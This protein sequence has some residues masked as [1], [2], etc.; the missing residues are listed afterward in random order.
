MKNH[1]PFLTI[2][3]LS[4]V[5]LMVIVIFFS[6]NKKPVGP[7]AETE[8]L[9]GINGDSFRVRRLTN[10]KYQRTAQRLK[11]GEYLTNGILQ[12]FACHSPRDWA[13]PGAPPIFDKRAS[14]GTVVSEDSTRRIIA[15]NITPDKETGAGNWTDDMLARSIREG[16]GHDGRALC[17]QMPYSYF[18]NLSDEDLASVIVYLRS[19][20]PVHSIVPSTKITAA[21]RS[22]TEKSLKPVLKAVF[23]S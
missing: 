1:K 11:Q 5:L 21:E 3:I 9:K 15:P 20:P 16:V 13:A 6:V 14:G 10:V 2:I 22:G 8:F 23:N 12:C 19:L 18:R 7:V 17:W 4:V